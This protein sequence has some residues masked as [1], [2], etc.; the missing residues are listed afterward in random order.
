MPLLFQR[1]LRAENRPITPRAIRDLLNIALDQS[2][3]TDAVGQPLRFAPPRGFRRM[4]R[5]L[6]VA[7]LLQGLVGRDGREFEAYL[8]RTNAVEVPD[9]D[10][11]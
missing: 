6:P 1:R 9:E 10:V 8:R 7:R 11:A 5:S 3:L 4:L 2:G